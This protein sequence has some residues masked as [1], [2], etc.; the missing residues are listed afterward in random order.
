MHEYARCLIPTAAF[1]TLSILRI[2]KPFDSGK[3]KYQSTT[4]P[5]TRTLFSARGYRDVLTK[6]DS[7]TPDGQLLCI[8]S[9]QSLLFVL[10]LGRKEIIQ[11]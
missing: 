2:E 8:L 7:P 9:C 10:I 11:R 4:V 3:G 1:K 5:L 6:A